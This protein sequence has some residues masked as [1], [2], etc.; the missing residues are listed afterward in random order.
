MNHRNAN[1]QPPLL[2]PT[3]AA[4]PVATIPA[5]KALLLAVVAF[6]GSGCMATI[7]E[8]GYYGG[9]YDRDYGPY[10]GGY[11]YRTLPPAYWRGYGPDHYIAGRPHRGYYSPYY[12]GR[13][14][15]IPHTGSSHGGYRGGTAR[16]AP[17][18]AAPVRG[19]TY[20]PPGRPAP[21]PN[22]IPT[23]NNR[24]RPN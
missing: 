1:L 11:A 24:K 5:A 2:P 10:Y 14:Y 13:N 6:F 23:T 12:S 21:A 15:G 22:A 16:V 20:N 18:A 19:A 17:A 4:R 8:P 3:P 7:Y 9:Y